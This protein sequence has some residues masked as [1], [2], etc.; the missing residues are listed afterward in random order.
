MPMV[1]IPFTLM[2]VLDLGLY[3]MDVK[4]TFIHGGSNDNIY[5]EKPEVS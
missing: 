3:Q 5:L 1:S 4:T 2:A